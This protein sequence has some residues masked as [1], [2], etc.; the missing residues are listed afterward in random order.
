MT[1]KREFMRWVV[2]IDQRAHSH[3][4][5]NF[6]AW[7]RAHDRTGA[8]TLDALHVVESRLLRLPE[9]PAAAAVIGRA[10]QATIAALTARK[11]VDA[12]AHV[13]AI[14]GEDV[15]ETLAAAGALA[16]TTG[17]IVG[18][19]LGDSDSGLVRL[20]K[21]ARRL[22]RRLDSPVCVVPP[23]LERAHLGA[24]PVIC[25]VTL[26]ERGL[27]AADFAESL[28]SAIGREVVLVHVVDGGDP[29]GL[30]YLPELTWTDMHTREREIGEGELQ[31]W[32]DQAKLG[33]RTLLRQGQ[34]VEQLVRAARELDGCM[35]V[36]GSRQ[37][38]VAERI[39]SSSVGSALAAAAHLPVIV[40]P[41]GVPVV[42]SEADP[43]AAQD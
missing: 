5:I 17:I 41:V 16:A 6:A 36:C 19:R 29:I 2:G 7:L 13:D 40:V 30:E 34:T 20:G 39:W 26:D 43:V 10:E 23:D 11:A 27:A 35:L 22:L 8:V 12:F 31:A 28:G 33:S 3:G 4:A 42:D 37:L 32:R 14:E 9:A 24:G 25:A 15:V 21:V 1:D 18:R 38:S